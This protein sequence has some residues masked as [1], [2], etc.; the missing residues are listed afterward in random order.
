MADIPESPAQGQ[1]PYDQL[2]AFSLNTMFQLS[3]H[4]Q[5]PLVVEDP[6]AAD[7]VMMMIA[8]A[9][10]RDLRITSHSMREVTFSLVGNYPRHLRS[11]ETERTPRLSRSTLQQLRPGPQ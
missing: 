10:A 9:K 5:T 11:V 1:D 6:A 3:T 7:G 8:K 4:P 2:A